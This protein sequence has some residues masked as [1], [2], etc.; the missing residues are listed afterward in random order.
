MSIVEKLTFEERAEV[1]GKSFESQVLIL[2]FADSQVIFAQYALQT[3]VE[4]SCIEFAPENPK[5]LI[6]GCVN[7]QLIS[8]D[9]SSQEHIISEGRKQNSEQQAAAATKQLD[10]DEEDKSQQQ[11]IK[12]KELIMSNIDKSHKNYVADIKFIP[13]DVKVDRKSP[14]DGKSFH[15]ISCSEDG[16]V[17][18]WDTRNIEI[19][20]LKHLAAK[21]KAAWTPFQTI[22][23]HRSEGGELGLSR[24]LFQ[25][26][27]TTTTFWAASDEGELALIDWSVRPMQVGEDV[28]AAE[29]VMRIYESE[30]N[31]R[32]V[33]ALERSPFYEDLL[34]TVHDFHFAIWKISLLDRE[35]PI[36][37]S[38]NTRG[39]QNT[40]GAFSPT[41]PGVIFITKNNGV[42]IWDFYD[43]S[44]K[45]SIQMNLA[46][47][48]ITYFKFQPKYEG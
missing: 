1:L 11:A 14:N 36:F 47:Q 37:R 2:N 9:M 15:F 23:L 8:W 34:M 5:V 22:Q 27:Q 48:T 26:D 24:I 33:L 16:Q 12:M 21:G 35:E 10:G 25:A 17:H 41:R 44:N 18:I 45:P 43:Q 42:D 46:S 31:S 6:G 38:A 3:P 4:I 19:T 7:G 39:S 40:C 13:K 29:C 30:R 32:P 28:R 20:E